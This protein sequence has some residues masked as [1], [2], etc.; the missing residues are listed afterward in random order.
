MI[1]DAALNQL[2]TTDLV[3]RLYKDDVAMRVNANPKALA[4]YTRAL[5]L[6]QHIGNLAKLPPPYA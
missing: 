5:A 3:R 4:H 1:L 6:A 2:E